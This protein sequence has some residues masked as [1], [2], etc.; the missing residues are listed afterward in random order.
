MTICSSFTMESKKSGSRM[1]GGY[2]PSK[3]SSSLAGDSHGVG[4]SDDDAIIGHL[5]AFCARLKQIIDVV[6]TMSQYDKSVTYALSTIAFM[7]VLISQRWL[8]GQHQW[9]F[10]IICKMCV[11]HK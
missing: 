2:S 11:N 8:S 9:M 5:E 10:G 1:A 4:M 7:K 6:N 3:K